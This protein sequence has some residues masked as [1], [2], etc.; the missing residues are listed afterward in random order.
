MRLES[1]RL[2]WGLIITAHIILIFNICD[3]LSL[4]ASGKFYEINPFTNML[5]LSPTLLILFFTTV[6]TMISLIRR[7]LS[8]TA[9][10]ALAITILYCTIVDMCWHVLVRL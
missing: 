6:V 5:L 8:K 4:M 2:F 1:T 10:T 7:F 3:T 9:G